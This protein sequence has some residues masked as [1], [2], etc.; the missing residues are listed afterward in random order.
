MAESFVRLASAESQEYRMEPLD[1]AA[2][3]AETV[4][5]LW[6]LAQDHGVKLVITRSPECAPLRG[7]RALLCRA[8]AN[9]INNAIK[10]SPRDAVVQCALVERDNR[11]VLSVRDA[12][13]GIAPE[14]QCQLFAPFQRL[15]DHSHP[16]VEGVGL[17]LALVHTV[18]LR[19]GGALEVDSD[20]GRGTEFRIVLPQQKASRQDPVLDCAKNTRTQIH[21]LAHRLGNHLQRGVA[22]ACSRK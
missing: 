19:H 11:W 2:V 15:H 4:D 5:D 12:G 10:F 9:V 3:L 1:M 17:G 16:A 22:A 8:V 20:L 7:D 18:V 6:A 14:L 21:A 13:P